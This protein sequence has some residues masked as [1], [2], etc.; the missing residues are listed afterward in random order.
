MGPE[1]P[2]TDLISRELGSYR[3]LRTI[4]RGGMSVVYLAEHMRLRRKVALKVLAAEL[5]EN[6]NFRKRFERESQLVAGMEHPHIVS[7][8]DAGELSGYLFIVMRYID[9]PDLRA[10]LKDEGR[11]QP[12]RALRITTEVASALDAAHAQ[13]LIH[14]DVKP[15]NILLA[16]AG[17]AQE[18]TYL[19]DFG[20]TKRSMSGPSLT[21]T[22]QFLGTIDYTAPEQIEGGTVDRRTDVY[23]LGCVLYQ[24]LTGTHPFPR[25]T[26]L[27]ILWAQVRDTAPPVSMRRPELGVRVDEVLEKAL[28]KSPDE[29]Y[30]SCGELAAALSGALGLRP[31]ESA[32]SGSHPAAPATDVELPPSAPPPS[33]AEPD[34]DVK[35]VLPTRAA[36]STDSWPDFTTA[37][38]ERADALPPPGLPESPGPTAAPPR[39]RRNRRALIGA[40]ALTIAALAAV[41]VAL[42][43][44]DDGTTESTARQ[45]TTTTAIATTTTEATTTTT[46]SV[47]QRTL[48]ST[49]VPRGLSC[50]GHQG[51]ADAEAA[52]SCETNGTRLVYASMHPAA[53]LQRHLEDKRASLAA[54]ERI[55]RD[56]VLP[57]THH[58][59]HHAPEAIEGNLLCYEQPDGAYLEWYQSELEVYVIAHRPDGNYE[60][61]YAQWA[62]DEFGP[63]HGAASEPEPRSEL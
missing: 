40:G 12:A 17:T 39:R 19:C 33:T 27:A 7:V 10:V 15:A 43:R 63:R 23:A 14:R 32:A 4:G 51:F 56:N 25:D 46:L 49:H 55:C 47:Q 54:P 52:V 22:G 6:E 48:L 50:R 28:A 31:V 29:R 1:L 36:A 35:P 3:I 2:Q 34:T 58:Y 5:A 59:H 11:L 21:A 20:L 8:Y 26:D 13:E 16:N 42:T 60:Q 45:Q 9:G 62:A 24:C 53:V 61:L 57:S 30:A 37:T 18:R 38:P 44:D 41:A